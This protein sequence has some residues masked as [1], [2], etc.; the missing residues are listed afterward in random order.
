MANTAVYITVRLEIDN[1]NVEEITEEEVES[2]VS[3]VEYEFKDVGDYE[4][5]SEICG[6]ND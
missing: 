4:I 3:E 1:P 5:T 2:I 6:I